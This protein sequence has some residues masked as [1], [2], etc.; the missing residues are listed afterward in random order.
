MKNIQ[1]AFFAL[2]GLFLPLITFADSS[3]AAAGIFAGLIGLF[4]FVIYFVFIGGFIIIGILGTILWIWML[5]DCAKRE[6]KNE[7]DK[8]LWILVIVLANTVGAIV[9]YFIIKR[10]Q[11]KKIKSKGKGKKAKGKKIVKKTG[12]KSKK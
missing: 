5:V 3:E 8:L 2:L 6:F 9:Y 4:I 11:D 10:E 12:E 7:N 1:K